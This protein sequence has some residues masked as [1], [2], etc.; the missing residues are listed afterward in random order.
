MF[1]LEQCLKALTARCLVLLAAAIG[2]PAALAVPLADQVI[3]GKLHQLGRR[4]SQDR[5]KQPRL[6]LQLDSAPN[7]TEWTLLITHRGVVQ[8]WFLEVNG[9][10]LS[11][12]PLS[13]RGE[14]QS[15]FTVP[16]GALTNG[17]NTLSFVAEK[18]GREISVGHVRLF[19]QPLRELLALRPVAVTV[20]DEQTG[21]P[22]PAR[23]TVVDERGEPAHLFWVSA[24]NTAVRTGRIY[25]TGERTTFDLPAGRYEFSATRGMEWGLARQTVSLGQDI[26]AVDL[27]LRRQVDTTGFIAADTH[28][29]TLTFSGHGDATI[30]ERMVTLA[31]EGVELAVATDHNH[32]TDYEPY[33][34]RLEMNPFFTPVT[35]NEVTTRNG[36]FNAFPLP[37]GGAVPDHR[38]SDWV[39]LM[40]E[41]RLKGAKVVIFNHPRY[42]DPQNNPLAKFRFNRASGDRFN[43]PAFTFNGMELVNSSSPSSTTREELTADPARLLIDWLAIQNRGEKILG[44]GGSDSHTVDD[45]VGQGRTYIRSSTDD[46]ARLDVDELCRNFLAGDTTVSYGIFAEVMV[47]GRHHPGGTVRP[48]DG[49]VVVSLRVAAADWIKPRRALVFLN[50]LPVAEKKLE[51]MPGEPFEQHLEFSIPTPQHDAYLVCAVFG[52]GITEPFWRTL[53]RFTA[54]VSNPV[55][56][57]GNGDGGYQSPRDTAQQILSATDSTLPAVWETIQKSDDALA[58]QMLGLL[59][60]SREADFVKQLDARVRTAADKRTL[61]QLFLETSPLVSE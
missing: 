43:G 15:Y 3:D 29:H 22:V 27:C 19:R 25:T 34:T 44:V 31:G 21:K 35:G 33:Q 59:Y 5:G 28:I 47:N 55:Y 61:Y 20:T 45:P 23:V 12:F 58:G 52:D 38:E 39:K 54:A 10:R 24:T 18:Y 37:P 46:P 17:L 32:H 30:E 42:P 36:H 16:A 49:K 8:P 48:A 9:R 1:S 56:I 26:T 60:L 50:G 13:Y 7:G 11:Q 51:P 57:D 2:L 14:V 4:G 41:I 40:A 53:G 6:D